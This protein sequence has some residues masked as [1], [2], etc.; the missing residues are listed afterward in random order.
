LALCAEGG[1]LLTQDGTPST[2]VKEEIINLEEIV[3]YP[4]PT[5]ERNIFI[6]LPLE[7]ENVLVEAKIYDLQGKLLFNKESINERVVQMP[8]EGFGSGIYFMRI[9]GNG[10]TQLKKFL[11]E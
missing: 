5:Q 6:K 9:E 1:G 4:N 3:V 10:T 11:I 8:L 2:M 7:L